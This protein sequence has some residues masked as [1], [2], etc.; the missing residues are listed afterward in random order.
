MQSKGYADESAKCVA[1][2]ARC[3]FVCVCVCVHKCVSVC[4]FG[5]EGSGCFPT[6]VSD[7]TNAFLE[8]WSKSPINTNSKPCGNLAQK[9]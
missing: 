4:F 3:V 7:L 8:E 2:R 6:S 1:G 9:S 5:G